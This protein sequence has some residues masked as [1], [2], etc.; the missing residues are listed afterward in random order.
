[1][2]TVPKFEGIEKEPVVEW[3]VRVADKNKKPQG[4]LRVDKAQVIFLERSF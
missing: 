3:W 4:W 1:M 2:D